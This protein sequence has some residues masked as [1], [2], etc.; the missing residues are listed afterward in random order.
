M[1]FIIFSQFLSLCIL[2]SAILISFGFILRL[3]ISHN[4]KN[5]SLFFENLLKNLV[6][7]LIAI[8]LVVSI[9]K[10]HGVTI[11][12]G[13]ILLGLSIFKI[14]KIKIV[15]PTIKMEVLR[16]LI[17]QILIAIICISPFYLQEF[18][19]F[20]NE[21][22]TCFKI[23]FFD[24]VYYAD[25]SSS[26][27]RF[28]NENKEMLKNFMF[29]KML[30]GVSPYHYFELWLTGFFSTLYNIS[31]LKIILLVTY[32]IL[33]GTFLIAIFSVFEQFGI[34]KFKHYL[35]SFLLLSVSGF[36][37]WFTKFY[38]I[39]KYNVGYTQNGVLAWGRKY[40]MLYIIALLSAN[41]FIKGQIKIALLTVLFIAIFSIGCAP[42]IIFTVGVF[43]AYI[44]IKNKDLE[45]AFMFL[46]FFAFF[47][48]FYYFMTI[49]QTTEYLNNV[50]LFKQILKTPLQFF[51]YKK[52]FFSFIYPFM[53]I[54][55]FYSPFIILA[56]VLYRKELI[57][58][59]MDSPLFILLL[60]ISSA[61]F[62]ALQSGMFDSGQ[63]LYN[64]L[65]ILNC[66]FM[67]LFISKFN[68]LKKQNF[69]LGIFFL[70]FGCN[71]I[72]AD[73]Y[74]KNTFPVDYNNHSGKFVLQCLDEI[75]SDNNCIVGL[76]LSDNIYKK[77]VLN[78]IYKTP[79]FF[80][81]LNNKPISIVDF[82]T[83]RF[84]QYNKAKDEGYAFGK[85]EM[86]LYKE[87]SSLSK[88]SVDLQIQFIKKFKINYL[89]I[90]NNSVISEDFFKSIM[91]EKVIVD[92]NTTDKFLKIIL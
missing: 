73:S 12:I 87:S 13:I 75:K 82:N 4:H 89:Y 45:L 27:M 38:E 67:V 31:S 30:E 61:F 42:G 14:K 5:D 70:M 56:L 91:I 17:R 8:V 6:F 92:E 63:L 64:N 66:F 2:S 37:F 44:A 84:K 69:F 78:A 50:G 23:P 76:S 79:C 48:S 62:S 81:H 47:V 86:N 25:I 1:R 41:Y 3:F 55:I 18:Y 15:W 20:T 43:I 28:G 46:L 88:G 58:F 36:Y 40:L 7:G 74:F 21:S 10:T 24:Y 26:L 32:P 34:L 51:L 65:P 53:R 68:S 49:P 83:F 60:L 22:A 29:P 19:Y 71:L 72:N 9:F 35:L 54:P 16:N 59:K 52:L 33:K 80:L 85:N 57:N 11:N 77:D 39:T 90:Q